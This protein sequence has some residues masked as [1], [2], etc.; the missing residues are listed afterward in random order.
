[1][2]RTIESAL[3]DAILAGIQDRDAVVTLES[4][5]DPQR[6]WIQFTWCN[7]NA[8]YPLGEHPDV[9]LARLGI[10]TRAVSLSD[11][12][13]NEYVTFGHTAE[14]QEPIAAFATAYVTRMLGIADPDAELVRE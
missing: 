3:G 10:D 5:T 2:G 6:A 11:W 4:A 1:M 12:R 8:A 14:L 7:V 13:P 9:A